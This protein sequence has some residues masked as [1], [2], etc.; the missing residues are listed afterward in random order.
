MKE[1]FDS[2]NT[3]RN[4]NI[5]AEDGAT[6]TAADQPSEPPPPRVLQLHKKPKIMPL[7]PDGDTEPYLATFERIVTVCCWP[8]EEWAI[9]L[10]PLLTG[11]AGSAYLLMDLNDSENYEKV[12]EVIL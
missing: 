2:T 8:Q 4:D 5:D 1:E 3:Q 10:I 6:A 7:S 11:K 12:K 9:Q